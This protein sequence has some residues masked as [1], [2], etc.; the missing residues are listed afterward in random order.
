MPQVAADAHSRLSENLSGQ[1]FRHGRHEFVEEVR[2]RASREEW[3]Q[4]VER[5]RDS[6]LTAAPFATETGIN[7]RTLTF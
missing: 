3:R 5:W 4:R 1:A 2:R 6:G 7:P